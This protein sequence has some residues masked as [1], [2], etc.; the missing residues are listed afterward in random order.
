VPPRREV[1]AEPSGGGSNFGLAQKWE[2]D[3]VGRYYAQ[4]SALIGLSFAAA[5]ACRV[6]CGLSV[7]ADVWATAQET[8]LL[9]A[10]CGLP[11]TGSG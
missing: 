2:G 7:G 8:P 10:A 4:Q 1:A 11:P 9:L 6:A 5:V 3:R